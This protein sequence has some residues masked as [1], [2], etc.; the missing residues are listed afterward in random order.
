MAGWLSKLRKGYGKKLVSLHA[1]NGWIVVV[2]AFTGLILFQGLWRGI[3]G[4]GR[5]IIRYVHIIV[6]IAS[7][8]PVVYYLL[9]AGKHW[10]QLRG[11]TAQK[12]NVIIVFALLVGWL[13]S[14]LLLWQFRAIGP[15]WS[16]N[17]LLVHDLLTWIG[18]PYV[19]YHSVTRLKWLKEPHR[20]TV[21]TGR[22]GEGLAVDAS[23]AGRN[24]GLHPAAKPTAVMS[25]ATFIKT[26]VGAGIAIAAGPSFLRWLGN[27]LGS[28]M[29]YSAAVEKDANRLIPAPSPLP[30]SS[31]P[32]GGG[33]KGSFRVY[34]VTPIPKFDNSNFSLTVEGLVEKKLQWNW[35][36]F[37]ALKREVQVSDFHCVTG[38]SVYSNTWEGIKLKDLLRMAG[39]KSSAKMVK[40]YSGDG[41][42]TDSL[43]LEQADMDDVIVAV[44]HDGQPIPSDLGGPVRLVV[45]KMY[46]YKSVKWLKIIELIDYDHTGYWEER[47]YSK[48]AWI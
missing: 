26:A 33:S 7:L 31:P 12:A 23:S 42:Y 41:V 2:L 43:T 17:A 8:L 39:V 15:R 47:G 4:E 37:V 22:V 28:G 46:A 21:K 24:D 48:D 1:W 16:S 45:P 14:G 20:R 13:I 35:E 5:V 3:L 40:F 11:K 32:I 44:L 19:I 6:G 30:A 9:L 10:K 27:Q 29:D 38:W 34:T 36:Q 25:R 18:L